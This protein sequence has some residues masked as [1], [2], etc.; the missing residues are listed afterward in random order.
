MPI[1]VS[2]LS[3]SKCAELR[4][5][6]LTHFPMA[7]F[8]ETNQ[9]LE[10]EVLAE[11]LKEAEGA[12]V[13]TETINETLLK[14]C[15]KLKIISKYGVGLD[16]IDFE[17]CEKYGVEVRF[18]PG[19][20]KRSVAEMTVC[21]MIGLCRNM[22]QTGTLL[23]QGTW[24]KKG[25]MQLSGKTVGIIG[26]GHVG[27]EVI[28]LLDPFGCNIL[29]NDIVERPFKL[30]S[31]EYIYKEA[32]IVSIHTPLTPE[33]YHLINEH[34]LK[35]MKPTAF[36]INTA[37]GKIID[38]MALKKVRIA[39]VALDVFE[40]EPFLDEGFLNLPHVFCTPH[41]GG[42]AKEAVLGMGEGAINQLLK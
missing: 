14:Q 23:K 31:K 18:T 26:A 41:I 36:L 1:Y 32:D 40:E 8:N 27:Q 20:N 39:G 5:R 11:F 30:S 7:V 25:G 42:N 35:Q 13:G 29:V 33:T 38:L 12:I 22:F 10:G 17:A 15:P 3:F 21:F 19:V 37:R 28:R 4:A 9:I 2:S 24:H 6:L 16:N 34:V